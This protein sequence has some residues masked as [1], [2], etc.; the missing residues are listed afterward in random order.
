MVTSVE[1]DNALNTINL[2]KLK[3]DCICFLKSK[4]F[5]LS[6]INAGGD[7]GL[8]LNNTTFPTL[9]NE[10]ERIVHPTRFFFIDCR[11]LGTLHKRFLY[12][13]VISLKNQLLLV[14]THLSLE[15]WEQSWLV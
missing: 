5:F 4:L 11:D 7:K 12:Y 14:V 2:Q 10:L 1:S 3:E 15:L 8:L 6:A 13:C 9:A